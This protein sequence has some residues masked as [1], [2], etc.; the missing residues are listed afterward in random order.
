MKRFRNI[1]YVSEPLVE[2]TSALARAVS[3]ADR[4]EA[5]LTVVSTLP[6]VEPENQDEEIAFQ[7]LALQELVAS[8]GQNQHILTDVLTG[9][10]FQA[11]IRTVLSK[12]YDLV[13]KAAENPSFLQRLFGSTDMHLL[14]KCPCPVWLMKVPEN[15]Q[16]SHILAAVD[17][18]PMQADATETTLNSEI[19]A[20]AS[21]LAM[22]DGAVLHLVH[23]WEGFAEGIVR[24]WGDKSPDEVAA[25]VEMERLRHQSALSSIEDSLQ[26]Q[27]GEEVYRELTPRYHLRKGSPQREIPV[28]AEELQA[29]LVVMGTLARTG[30]SGL[31][32]GNTAETI[33][34]QLPCS[35]LAIKPPGF[36]SPVK[37]EE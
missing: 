3:L 4:H 26:K 32:I 31:F 9:P 12:G 13:I 5:E 21:A 24:R 1:L 29:D 16:Y 27:V 28:L 6:K 36:I 8:H 18:N 33:L 22:A 34:E 30:I 20:L 19:L 17:V 10:A 35:V 14:R 15:P 7:R 37:G 2:Q 11:I 23:A 25:Y